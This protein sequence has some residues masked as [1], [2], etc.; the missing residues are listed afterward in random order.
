MIIRRVITIIRKVKTILPGNLT[1]K[2]QLSD[3]CSPSYLASPRPLMLAAQS[4]HVEVGWMEQEVIL[5]GENLDMAQ[6]KRLYLTIWSPQN[7][8]GFSSVSHEHGFSQ[9]F[10]W[11]WPAISTSCR[12]KSCVSIGTPIAI[13]CHSHVSRCSE[14]IQSR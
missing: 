5:N 11:R 12:T 10:F 8:S 9:P 2:P 14:E 6:K 4:G 1:A 3:L 7:P 13:A